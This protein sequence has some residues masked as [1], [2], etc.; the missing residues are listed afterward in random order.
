MCPFLKFLK[1]KV[2]LCMGIQKLVL[3]DTRVV[4]WN[5]IFWIIQ[6]WANIR[7]LDRFQQQS[8]GSSDSPLKMIPPN[9]LGLSKTY[10]QKKIYVKYYSQVAQLAGVENLG[11][12]TECLH[13]KFPSPLFLT[14]VF[15]FYYLF[16]K[17]I[18]FKIYLQRLKERVCV[19]VCVCVCVFVCSLRVSET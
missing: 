6:F 4:C 17:V 12:V 2:L 11:I 13:R 1:W 9:W 7:V 5:F 15:V 3:F 14:C 19:C 18:S 8:L 16:N 10:K